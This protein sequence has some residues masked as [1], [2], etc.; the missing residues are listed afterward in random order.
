[1]KTRRSG[2]GNCAALAAAALLGGAGLDVDDGGDAL[3]FLHF[4]LDRVELGTLPHFHLR[5]EG[6]EVDLFLRV[7]DADHALHAH[8]DELVGDLLGGQAALVRLAAG[9]RDGVV[10]ED[11]VGDVDPRGE[12]GAN[13]LDARVVVG[14]VAEVLE[15]VRAVGERRLADPVRPLA[16]H[17]GEL[18]GRAVHPAHHVVAA[19]AGVAAGAFG[20][21]R[22]GVVRAAGAEPGLADR[23]LLGVVGAHGVLEQRAAGGEGFGLDAVE[24][25]ERAEGAGDLDRVEGLLDREDR[26]ARL[27]LPAGD[28]AAAA[29]VEDRFLDLHLDELALLLDDDDVLEVV[30][31][32]AEARH[33]ERPDHADL[34]GGDPEA[35]RLGGADAEQVE[36]VRGVEPGLARGD[37]ADLRLGAPQHA[38]VDSI[39]AGKGFGGEALV[40]V[41]ARLLGHGRVAPADV[42]AAFGQDEVGRGHDPEA[43]RVAVHHLGD[44][45]RVLDALQ[46][47]PA[48]GVAR[49]RPA[50]EPVVE[51]LLDAGRREDRHHRVDEGELRVVK[52]RRALAG[53]VVAKAGDHAAELGGAGHVG[54]AEDVAAAVDAGALAVPETEDPL[55]PPLAVQVDLLAAPER[56]GGEILVEA[57]LELDVGRLELPAGLPH[58]LVD[59]AQGRTAVA[60]GVARRTEPRRLVAR[61]LHEQDADQRRDAAEEHVLLGEVE[62]VRERDVVE[63]GNP[64]VENRC[65]ELKYKPERAANETKFAHSARTTE[66][67]TFGGEPRNSALRRGF[68]TEYV[69]MA[70]GS[71]T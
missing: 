40:V 1:M 65:R 28:A 49:E 27:V 51:H 52:D 60:G 41:Q 14:A 12:G 67:V 5:G 20:Q 30:R 3:D 42:E 10:E 17:V 19:D 8:G 61:L 53:V 18:L 9:H 34:V 6:L 16:A 68:R 58:L 21:A 2:S 69:V 46:A 24:G 44:L 25:E 45:D 23:D 31:P 63:H 37:D 38:A 55:H 29:V 43:M 57:R 54:V 15:H 35:L 70:P 39:G 11:L 33:V 22:R 66:N 64:R 50:E 48:A 56:G 32:L 47:H 71:T 4:A 13:R 7:V 26:L 62:A 59:A 36:R